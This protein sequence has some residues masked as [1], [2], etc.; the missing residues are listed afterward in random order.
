L[1]KCVLSCVLVASSICLTASE[2]SAASRRFD[3]NRCTYAGCIRP[4]MPKRYGNSYQSRVTGDAVSRLQDK[5]ARQQAKSRNASGTS[6][7][8]Y[9]KPNPY[10]L[11]AHS[12]FRGID[13]REGRLL[14]Q[15]QGF[16]RVNPLE[17]QGLTFTYIAR[18][19]GKLVR[20]TVDSRY[21]RII[22]TR[23]F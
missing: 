15:G 19:N 11:F 13:C 23:P 1:I 21:G 6:R 9:S 12:P 18:Q 3:M 8:Q 16:Y 20:V 14:V 22:G 17:C 7:N 5:I 2:G 10:R 4:S